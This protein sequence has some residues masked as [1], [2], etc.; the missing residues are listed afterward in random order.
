MTNTG[1]DV[2]IIRGE[3]LPSKNKITTSCK[4]SAESDES[5]RSTNAEISAQLFERNSG[6]RRKNKNTCGEDLG[7]AVP[8]ADGDHEGLGPEVRGR[9][10]FAGFRGVWRGRR[11]ATT[12]VSRPETDPPEPLDAM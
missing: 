4:K 5:V 3:I 10:V 12:I 9:L 1:S 2:R 11:A 8:R 6:R 7:D